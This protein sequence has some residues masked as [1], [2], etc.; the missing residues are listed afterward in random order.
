MELREIDP[1]LLLVFDRMLIG[2]RVSSVAPSLGLSQP[3]ISNAL[4]RLGR[5]LGDELFLRTA[6]GMV[7]TPYALQLAG[8]VA[9]AVRLLHGALNRP[10]EFEPASSTRVF[11]LAMTDIGDIYFTPALM[12]APARAAP[13]V[14]NQHAAQQQQAAARRVRLP[15]ITINLFWHARF[16][17]DPGNHWLRA[18]LFDNFADR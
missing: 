6:G 1:N 2:K 3:A 15:P 14:A 8:L 17:R 7:P 5:L 9:E 18:L 16:H 4:A 13:G 12:Q 11:T 10:S